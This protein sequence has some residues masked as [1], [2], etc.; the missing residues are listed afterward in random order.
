MAG[1]HILL[2]RLLVVCIIDYLDEILQPAHADPVEVGLFLLR[3]GIS[4]VS[5]ILALLLLLLEY[6]VLAAPE[7]ALFFFLQLEHA[8]L[9][10]RLLLF[11]LLNL[12]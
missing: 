2:L 4:I 10:L 1:W 7:N 8:L 11:E 9:D 5:D 3:L 6:L 12:I